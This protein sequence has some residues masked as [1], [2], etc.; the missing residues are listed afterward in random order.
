MLR[1]VS[2]HGLSKKAAMEIE[3]YSQEAIKT[4]QQRAKKSIVLSLGLVGELGGLCSVFK[5]EIRDGSTKYMSRKVE[6]LGDI[7]WYVNGLC[8]HYK[9]SL[10]K[11]M[12]ENLIATGCNDEEKPIRTFD[13][14]QK[15]VEQGP[16]KSHDGE[17]DGRIAGLSKN[18]SNILAMLKARE[19]GSPEIKKSLEDTLWYCAAV[20][21]KEG[22]KF[23]EVA[24]HNLQKVKDCYDEDSCSSELFDKDDLPDE[25]IPRCFKVF[26]VEHGNQKKHVKISINHVVVGDRLTDN[27]LVDDGY[28]FHDIFHLAYLAVLGWSPVMRKLLNRKRKSKEEIDEVEDGARA[29]ITEETISAYV[30][31]HAR[32]HYFINDEEIDIEILDTI[33]ALT[34]NYEVRSRKQSEWRKAIQLG[35]A[36]FNKLKTEHGGEITVDLQNKSLTFQKLSMDNN[37]IYQPNNRA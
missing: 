24:T 31:E 12:N 25:Q 22:I 16:K 4:I 37:E 10:D 19:A 36:M 26:F 14:Y 34:Q 18:I 6:E 9:F 11:L 17:L 30:F 15:L 32:P 2:N 5:K 29:I 28:R 7:L 23:S 27:A 13:E 21:V 33:K 35:Y 20:C 8:C 1:S 3:H